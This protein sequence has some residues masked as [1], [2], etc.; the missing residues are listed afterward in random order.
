MSA[1]GSRIIAGAIFNDNKLK[2]SGHVRIL[3][4]QDNNAW[5]Q[6]GNN[7]DSEAQDDHFGMSVA[8]SADGSRI[9]V[10]SWDN[11]GNGSNSSGI[12]R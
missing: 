5:L 8:I 10:G 4:F 1:D 12:S 11:D 2:D 6:L 9:A 3:E 7:I